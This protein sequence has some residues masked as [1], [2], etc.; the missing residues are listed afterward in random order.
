[1]RK[2]TIWVERFRIYN[3][4][5]QLMDKIKYRTP[6]YN[7]DVCTVEYSLFLFLSSA[8]KVITIK[9]RFCVVFGC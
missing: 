6:H 3:R 7:H 9:N 2:H 1:M 8:V 5:T 4:I